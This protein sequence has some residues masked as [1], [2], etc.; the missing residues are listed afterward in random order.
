[1]F[2]KTI[3]IK[4]SVINVMSC[5][6]FILGISYLN[7]HPEYAGIDISFISVPTLFLCKIE[8]FN[9]VNGHKQL[10]AF[11]QVINLFY[12]KNKIVKLDLIKK[13]NIIKSITWCDK[14]KV[15]Y[16][17]IGY[18]KTNIFLNPQHVE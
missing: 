13:T 7:N 18:T 4:P 15:P 10:D 8:E 14:Q 1:M 6:I 17:K 2:E 12:N 5:D 9:T 16:N 3:L 11:E